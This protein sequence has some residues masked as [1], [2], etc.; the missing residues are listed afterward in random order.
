[1]RGPGTRVSLTELERDLLA[2]L[3]E[4]QG[5]AVSR[6]ELLANVW[7]YPPTVQSRCVDT[8]VRRLRRKIEAGGEKASVLVSVHGVGY[9]LVPAPPL[10]VGSLRPDLPPFPLV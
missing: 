6:E 7:H 3:A 8:T 9:R 10:E 1:M 2:Y 5:Q 4:R